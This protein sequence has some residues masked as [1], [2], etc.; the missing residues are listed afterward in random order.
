MLQPAAYLDRFLA[1]GVRPDGRRLLAARRV[2]CSPACLST[3]DGSA[4][5]RLGA[6]TIFAGVSITPAELAVE[7]SFAHG[8]S[9]ASA[10]AAS[11]PLSPA[12]VEVVVELGHAAAPRFRSRRVGSCEA[13]RSAAIA[14][15][16]RS[17]V[18]GVVPSSELEIAAG[19]PGRWRLNLSLVCTGF[20]G[21]AEEACVL[22]ATAAL[23]DATVPAATMDVGSSAW[24]VGSPRGGAASTSPVGARSA[25][26]RCVPGRRLKIAAV[27]VASVFVAVP[28][29]VSSDAAGAG[30]KRA[31][32]ILAD[33]T[34]A[35]EDLAVASLCLVVVSAG[36]SGAGVGTLVMRTDGDGTAFDG[37]VLAECMATAA[38]RVDAVE[39]VIAKRAG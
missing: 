29:L 30:G 9:L 10:T 37:A 12:D 38:R 26:G 27:P 24:R 19:S 25:E 6:T 22:A 15:L 17:V 8:G 20:D 7:A 31:A 35:E 23:M 34:A 36:G 13:K 5:V 14:A 2:T 3:C 32:A 18:L 28:P 33:P 16:V 4:L 1:E 21:N 11:K 39:A